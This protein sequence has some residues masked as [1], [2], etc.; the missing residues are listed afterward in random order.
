[1]PAGPSRRGRG[2]ALAVAAG[3]FLSRIAG[4]VRERVFAHYLGSSD[5]AGA[6]KA[7]LRI[8]NLLQNLFGEGVLS[9]SFIPVYAR[10]LGQGRRD[11]AG[12][13]AGAVGALVTFVTALLVALGVT[14]AGPLTEVVAPG[15]KGEVRELTV[16]L[17]RILFAGT[18]LL[19]LSAWCLGIL[20]SHRRF[21][22]SYVAPV[23][24]NAAQIAALFVFG[25]SLA[26]APGDLAT[27]VAW[28]TVVGSALQL[29]VQLPGAIALM[30]KPID[31][32]SPEAPP[33]P[34]APGAPGAPGVP[35]SKPVAEVVRNFGP[36]LVGRGVVQI[37]AYIDQILASYLGPQ[38]VA[39]IAYAQQLYLL[40]ISLFGM[41]VSAAELPEM[42]RTV[43][44]TVA[45]EVADKLRARLEAG[46]ER[47][48]FFV[49][50]SMIAFAVLGD[51]VV[52][53]L[54]QTGRFGRD[55]TQVV[56]M[57]LGGS[58]VG[59]LAATMGRLV[60]SCFYALSDTRTPLRCALA[61]V[62][63]GAALG[64][65]IA[66]PLRTR[67]GWSA[68]VGAAGLTAA[69][70]V[71]AWLELALLARG[72]RRRVGRFRLF[73]RSTVMAL[74]AAAIAA[75]PAVVLGRLFPSSGFFAHPLVRGPALL[76]LFGALYLGLALALGVPTAQSLRN[77]LLRRRS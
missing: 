20:N 31:E 24:W 2:G 30:R 76:G 23:L 66:L 25:A 68:A 27:K 37:A 39:A 6:F 36:V 26:N 73:G 47:I 49:V 67:L 29:G 12:R 77:R 41:A 53:T 60:S 8:P 13:V 34:P 54:Y 19:V 59:L 62:T 9:A 14:V 18:G 21:F 75:S 52:G 16:G 22:L 4:L 45:G 56:W 33:P 42:A 38:S 55:D 74:A 71:A 43:G 58:S 32:K 72:L 17:V 46:L 1:M 35:A 61:R 70:G 48:A 63:V 57:I 28:G 44:A 51:A 15:Y 64:Y 3:I 40:P 65:A 11:E 7:A 69:S 10:L 5:A 50:P